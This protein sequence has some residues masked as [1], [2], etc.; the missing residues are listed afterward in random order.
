MQNWPTDAILFFLAAGFLSLCY[1]VISGRDGASWLKTLLK[2]ASVAL[3]ALVAF[4]LANMLLLAVA[5]LACAMGDFFLSRQD[6]ENFG[7]ENSGTEN[8]VTG[9]GA[10]GF[11]HLSY[12]ALFFL[13]PSADLHRISDGWPLAAALV[14]LGLIM[15]YLLFHKAGALRW[16]ALFYVPVIVLMGILSM[17]LPPVG[18]LVLVLPAALL[19]ILSDFILA[20]EMFVLPQGHK[21]RRAT[22]YLIWSSYWLAQALF[23]LAFTASA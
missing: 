8:I 5:L 1:L 20:Q 14:L 15:L 2:T 12:A 16:A 13:H 22:P 21:L 23:L 7:T 10:F 4:Q 3:L 17:V 11:G 18:A 9:I 19:F 6:T